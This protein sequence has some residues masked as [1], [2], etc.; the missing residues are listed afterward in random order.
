MRIVRDLCVEDA[1]LV[2]E[3]KHVA[4]VARDLCGVALAGC[5]AWNIDLQGIA[6]RRCDMHCDGRAVAVECEDAC[7]APVYVVK[8]E[9]QKCAP[10]VALGGAF[11]VE[12]GRNW[13]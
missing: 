4:H 10:A 11:E 13:N 9:G 7:D 5:A 2:V 12:G 8:L 3:T 1:H 6:R